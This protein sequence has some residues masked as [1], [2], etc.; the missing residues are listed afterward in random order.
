MGYKSGVKGQGETKMVRAMVGTV[1]GDVCKMRW[2][3]RRV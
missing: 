3:R 1:I 2:T